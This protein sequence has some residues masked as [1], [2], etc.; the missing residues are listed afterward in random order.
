MEICDP[1]GQDPDLGDFKRALDD[2]DRR[3]AG[4]PDLEEH[5]V[6]IAE[7]IDPERENP[8]LSMAVAIVLY[9]VHRRH[10]IDNHPVDILR[11]AA[12]TEWNGSPPSPIQNWLA[13]HGVTV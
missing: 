8:A 9:L 10:E 1:T 6:G 13:G 3:V 7:G 11:L 2:D 12:R 5:L 4:V